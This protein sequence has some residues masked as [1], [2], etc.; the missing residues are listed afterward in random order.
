MRSELAY[1][2]ETPIRKPSR[3]KRNPISMLG[4]TRT[5]AHWFCHQ[6]AVLA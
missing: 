3:L 6:N 1:R 2:Q 5:M 4:V